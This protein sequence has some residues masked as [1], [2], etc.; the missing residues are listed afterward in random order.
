MSPSKSPLWY[1]RFVSNGSVTTTLCSPTPPVLSTSIV[2]VI[3]SPTFETLGT[4]AAL[5]IVIL[6][7]GSIISTSTQAVSSSVAEFAG[8]SP[9]NVTQLSISP[10]PPP[11][12][13]ISFWVVEYD[14]VNT[15]TSD[16][17]NMPSLPISPEGLVRFPP[18]SG[19]LTTMLCTGT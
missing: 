3:V 17:P 19:S 8:L 5:E 16:S 12:V 11:L 15:Q 2:Y 14:S 7:D 6:A 18:N 13:S 10:S 1:V 4:S 9:F